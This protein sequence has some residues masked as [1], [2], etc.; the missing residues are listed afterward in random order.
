MEILTRETQSIPSR[1]LGLF[2]LSHY[3][4]SPFLHGT[5]ASSLRRVRSIGVSSSYH[6]CVS[7]CA[8]VV[9]HLPRPRRVSSHRHVA[10]RGAFLTTFVYD[11]C[12]IVRRFS[13]RQLASLFW[14]NEGKRRVRVFLAGI[15]KKNDEKKENTIRGCTFS[16]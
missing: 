12:T 11:L 2:S 4:V 1:C 3:C 13:W 14:L 15:E 10:A 7:P 6:I 5:I 9:A 8:L 16:T